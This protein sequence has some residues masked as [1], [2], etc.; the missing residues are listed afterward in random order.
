MTSVDITTVENNDFDESDIEST[1]LTSL[2][3]QDIIEERTKALKIE[4]VPLD[5]SE[6]ILEGTLRILK[7]N[8]EQHPDIQ[9]IIPV[10]A[11][12]EEG[13]LGEIN[14][15]RD[16][17]AR[18][19][20]NFWMLLVARFD[21][22]ASLALRAQVDLEEWGNYSTEAWLDA[23]SQKLLPWIIQR[24]HKFNPQSIAAELA[25]MHRAMQE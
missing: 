17:H 1:A 20:T 8:L 13:I 15:Y 2:D 7:E 9:Y 21:D 19:A 4:D 14:A 16:A 11:D 5:E 23:F 3:I 22:L 6:T 25:S 18:V 12:Q 10:V 24:A